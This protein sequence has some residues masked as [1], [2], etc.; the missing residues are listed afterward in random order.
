MMP[1]MDGF[2]TVKR[3]K[4]E[5]RLERIPVIALTAYAMLDNIEVIEKNGFDDLVTKPINSEVLA[6]KMKKFLKKGAG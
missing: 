5:K 6:V 3:I 2:E 4:S 1:Q